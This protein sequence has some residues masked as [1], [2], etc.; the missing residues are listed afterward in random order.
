VK[1]GGQILEIESDQM[2]RQFA[3][4][5]LDDLGELADPRGQSQLVTAVEEGEVGGGKCLYIA[6]PQRQYRAGPAG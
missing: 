1:L 3:G 4:G 5:R 2:W 6:A